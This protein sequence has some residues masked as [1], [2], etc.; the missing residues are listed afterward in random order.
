ARGA[1]A[2]ARELGRRARS[3]GVP[4]VPMGDRAPTAER[5]AHEAT[6]PL[7]ARA[8]AAPDAPPPR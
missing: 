2:W 6:V 5:A 7:P 8:T 3:G 1:L 4:V